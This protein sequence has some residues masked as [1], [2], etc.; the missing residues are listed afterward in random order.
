MRKMIVGAGSALAI[1]VAGCGEPTAATRDAGTRTWDSSAGYSNGSERFTLERGTIRH[2]RSGQLFAE[3]NGN[4]LTV[5]RAGRA[6]RVALPTRGAG[7]EER[8]PGAVDLLGGL[9]APQVGYQSDDGTSVTTDESGECFS[10]LMK[11]IGTA[12]ALVIAVDAALAASIASAGTL[13]PALIG[14]AII[15]GTAYAEAVWKYNTCVNGG[16]QPAA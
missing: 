2:Y 8:A 7:G 14:A 9:P 11:V 13:T 5:H 6:L 10:E 1:L 15:A 16:E 12:T 4:V 3:L